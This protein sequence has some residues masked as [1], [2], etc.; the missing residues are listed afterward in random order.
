M[1]FDSL[2]LPKSATTLWQTVAPLV[3]VV[4]VVIVG[5]RIPLPGIDTSAVA[6]QA[7]GLSN[8]AIARFS[9][10]ALGAMPLFTVLTYAE[11]AKLAFPSFARWQAASS[12]N[13]FRTNVFIKSFVLLLAAIQGVWR[14]ERACGHGAHGWL[15]GRDERRGYVIRRRFRGDDLAGRH[16]AR[17]QSG[18]WRLVAA[19]GS[20]ARDIAT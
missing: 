13:T 11:I 16:G 2:S 15:S 8:D 1:S 12:E 5:S 4:I 19:G 18:E 9:V 14:H 6:E 3:P 7:I 17:I 20:S 10:F